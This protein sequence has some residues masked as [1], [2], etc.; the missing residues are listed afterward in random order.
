MG[1]VGPGAPLYL[2]KLTWFEFQ[3]FQQ[4]SAFNVGSH[5][6][7]FRGT[8]EDACG[9]LKDLEEAGDAARR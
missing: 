1:G 9:E 6:S 8:V 2:I 4:L 7:C 3:S 5:L